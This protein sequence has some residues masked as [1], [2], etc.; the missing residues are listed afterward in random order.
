MCAGADASAVTVVQHLGSQW[1]EGGCL[2]QVRLRWLAAVADSVSDL[3][4]GK[5]LSALEAA[6][7]H[8]QPLVRYAARLVHNTGLVANRVL[9]VY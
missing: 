5:L 2:E 4:G 6:A 1:G 8:G 3:A 9:A 7:A